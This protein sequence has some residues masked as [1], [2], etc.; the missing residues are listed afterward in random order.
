[1][2]SVFLNKRRLEK[3]DLYEPPLTQ[4]GRNAAD[5]LFSEGEIKELI[6]F[7]DKLAA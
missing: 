3:A 6:E 7:T 1:V 4:F 2:R 5:R